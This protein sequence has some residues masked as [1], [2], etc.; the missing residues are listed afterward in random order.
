M[1]APDYQEP[2]VTLHEHFTPGKIGVVTVTFNSGSVLPDFFSSIQQQT[3][4]T[5]ELFAVDNASKDDTIKRLRDWGDPRLVLITNEQNLGVAAGNNQGIRAAIIS[6]CEYILLLNNDVVFGAELFQQLLDGMRAHNCQ[7]TTPI[8]YYHDRPNIIWAAGGC[9][10]PLF[11]YRGVLLGGGEADQGQYGMPA[12]VQH[13]PTCCVLFERGVFARI[14]LMDE[15]YFVYHDDTDFMLRA[16]KL[17]ERLMLLP[18]A[19]LWHKVSSLTGNASEFAIRYG[20]RNRALLL[21][22][23]LGRALFMPY[24]AIYRTYYFTRFILGRDDYRT[25]RLKQSS[26]NSGARLC[27]RW[28][29]YRMICTTALK[30][31]NEVRG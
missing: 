7:M 21:A 12:V 2:T 24:D 15:R 18:K 27:T 10:Q 25:L 6:G 23:F 19:K 3:C 20:T 5:F 16:L 17:N 4:N 28:R 1:A 11:G 13:A 31:D 14:G 30:A 8:I 29:P 9:F 22:K 26:W